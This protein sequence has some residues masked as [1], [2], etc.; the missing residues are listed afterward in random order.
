VPWEMLQIQNLVRR[1]DVISDE[2][3]AGHPGLAA[4]LPPL[5][6]PGD[7]A[8]GPARQGL[9][10]LVIYL[11]VFVAGFGLALVRHLDVPR[12]GQ[13]YVD[14][15]MFI[16]YWQWWPYAISHGHNPLYTHAI[17]APTGWNLAAW[18][19]SAPA[20]TLLMAPVTAA[21]GPI[22]SFNLTLL[23]APPTAA[24]AAFVVARRLTRRFWAALL[25]GAV[26]GF[27]IYEVSHDL[28][29][30]PNLTVTLLFPF[31]V[32]LVLLWW[33]GTLG[34]TGFVVLT[35]LAL[36]L[37]FYTFTE[38]F[39]DVTLVTAA[40]LV[41]GFAVAGRA[42]RR[43]VVRLAELIAVAYAGAL[44]LASPYLLDEVMHLPAGL[45][46]NTPE[47][48]LPLSAL[49]VPRPDRLW[50]LSPALSSFS[51]AHP[52]AGYVGI[53][54]VLLL[55]V[56]A[57]VT[58]SSKVTRL[59]VAM[60]VVVL[61]LAAGPR[62]MIIAGKPACTLPWSG[63]WDLPM[64]RSAEPGRIILFGYLVLAIVLALWLAAP[65]TSRVL[66]AARWGLAAVALAAMLANLG[67]FAETVVPPPPHYKPA[68][69]SL[70]ATDTLPAFITKGLY[71][72]YLK[73]GETVVV[74]SHRGNAGMLFQA[75]TDFYFQI[76]GG[77][78]NASLNDTSALPRP[79]EVLT[80]L[81]GAVGAQRIENFKV[82]FKR[83]HI[84]AIIVERAW[85]E[86]WMYVFGKLGMQG[87]TVGGVTVY[88]PNSRRLGN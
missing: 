85:S 58:W 15:N 68:V 87:T 12:V 31:L 78:I 27:N 44:V 10:A 48:S 28:S 23:L 72:R 69:A 5:S 29:G 62:L 13:R 45:T 51:S 3:R 70:R 83:T 82:Y 49:V 67:T 14:P 11:A 54:L 76:A 59:L 71:R 46:H 17:G 61:A 50:G 33:D 41:I 65:A 73:P 34:R 35:A 4:D 38:Y 30:Q 74:L 47:F 64:A 18:A 32:Y 20:V 26:Y 37:E 88:R 84:G 81:P 22:A 7:R 75:Y 8:P 42:T 40:A 9:L 19:T 24:W 80:H 63:L 21:F 1:P 25:A 57:V 86:R 60:L 16:W 52:Q 2:A 6:P 36:A 39:F 56:F 79:V 55:L 66:V 77:F 53:P 43:T